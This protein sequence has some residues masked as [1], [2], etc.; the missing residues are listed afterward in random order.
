[1]DEANGISPPFSIIERVF[2][3]F[4]AVKEK[5]LRAAKMTIFLKKEKRE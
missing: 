4:F 1:L 5:D 2:A 3:Q